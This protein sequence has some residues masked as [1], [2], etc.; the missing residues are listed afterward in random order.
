S[1]ARKTPPER[2]APAVVR[3][4]LAIRD[5]PP[6]GL[7]RVPGP[8]TILY[9]L[10]QDEALRQ[11]GLKLP[12]STSTIWH[13][14]DQNQRIARPS[15]VPHQPIDRPE[16][17]QV[18]EIDFCDIST[19]PP[20]PEG[21]QQHVVEAF[22]VVDRGT[23]I[24]VETAVQADYHAE[25][26]VV[27][28]LSTLMVHGMPQRVIMDRDPRLI[29][30]GSSEGYPSALM[31]M[32]LSLGIG[33][34][35]CPPRQ[36]QRKPVVERLQRTIKYEAV[37]IERPATLEAARDLLDKQSMFYNTDRPNQATVCDNQPPYVAFPT[38]P[39]LPRLPERIDPDGW[40]RAYHNHE[41]KRRITSNGTIAVGK[42]RYYIG[43][44]WAGRV[45]ALRIDAHHKQLRVVAPHDIDKVLDIKGLYHGEMAFEEYVKLIL[46]EARAEWRRLRHQRRWKTIS[47]GIA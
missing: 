28:V 10:H 44:R 33:M 4:I 8:R 38:L 21:K 41:L 3:N 29:G 18:W 40:L 32:L 9:Y 34:T 36:P 5:Q 20:V 2:I 16:P 30:S 15:R 47:P 35:I 25:T 7:N 31:R 19:V 46:E 22:N 45:V 26:A 43:R 6:E 17:M 1:R 27:A 37:R 13:I 23:S 11:S 39:Q 42:Y 24:W 12:T 14:L